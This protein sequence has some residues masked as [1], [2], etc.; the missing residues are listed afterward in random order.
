M[1]DLEMVE[2]EIAT[3][4]E[5]IRVATHALDDPSLSVEGRNRE[6]ASIEFYQR[7]LDDLLTKRDY[8]Q[9]QSQG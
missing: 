1:T 5:S 8:L 4:Q 7:H 6:R 2:R 9:A 3:L